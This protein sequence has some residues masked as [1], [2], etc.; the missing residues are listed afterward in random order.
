[1]PEIPVPW[2]ASR[3]RGFRAIKSR[4]GQFRANR[5]NCDVLGNSRKTRD[6]GLRHSGNNSQGGKRLRGAAFFDVA[7]GRLRVGF[8][9][10][11]MPKFGG[12]GRAA[13][14]PGRGSGAQN[15]GVQAKVL[16][17]SFQKSGD[18]GSTGGFVISP[19]GHGASGNLDFW[20]VAMSY[21]G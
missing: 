12:P 5:R 14:R 3:G 8:R 6:C 1:M 17:R 9:P 2:T 11:T 18:F 7:V 15:L 13:G 16:G 10:K 19:G 21:G 20:V 4:I